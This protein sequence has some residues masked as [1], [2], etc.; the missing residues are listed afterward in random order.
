MYEW[1]NG[2]T[3]MRVMDF[4]SLKLLQCVADLYN[5][6]HI[7]DMKQFLIWYLRC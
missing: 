3:D 7:A 1:M 5:I 4:T 2:Q 6:K